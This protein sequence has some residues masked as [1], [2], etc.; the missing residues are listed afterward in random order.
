[1]Y[2]ERTKA[3]TH[4]FGFGS[5]AA[6]LVE[7]IRVSMEAQ[8]YRSIVRND[9]NDKSSTHTF[10]LSFKPTILYEIKDGEYRSTGV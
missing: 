1:M 4:T 6:L 2:E 7:I 3:T 8:K 5:K 10:C 9:G